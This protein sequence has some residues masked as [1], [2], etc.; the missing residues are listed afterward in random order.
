MD[1]ERVSLPLRVLF[2]APRLT[3]TAS[4]STTPP[5]DGSP[6]MDDSPKALADRGVPTLHLRISECLIT[7]EEAIISTV[8][9]S[10]VSVTFFHKATR[11]AAM[12]HA[13]LPDSALA[14]GDT[15]E[16]CKF[17]DTAMERILS[18]YRQR[19]IPI[20][21][22]ETKLF[23]GAYSLKSR[24]K[25]TACQ[26]MVDVGAKNVAA[27]DVLLKRHG[28]KP[29][30]RQV[31]GDRGRKILMH[32]HSGVVWMKHLAAMPA[33]PCAVPPRHDGAS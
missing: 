18:P 12:F 2:V 15:S 8:L 13:M 26:D 21:E 22:L 24:H 31:M 3:Y 30:K 1:P 23:G 10:C 14:R 7:P 9:G 6:W 25:N 17:V 20:A 16:P 33:E 19:R 27:A 29:V 11:V 4:M 28:L 5:P 32:T